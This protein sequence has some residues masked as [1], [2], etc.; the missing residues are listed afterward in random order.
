MW[1]GE[2]VFGS[3]REIDKEI[4]AVNIFASALTRQSPSVLS[5]WRKLIEL[6]PTSI[7]QSLQRRQA[8]LAT[9][10]V[11]AVDHDCPSVGVV[12][13][14]VVDLQLDICGTV[15]APSGLLQPTNSLAH[16]GAIV[17]SMNWCDLGSLFGH[18]ESAL[19]SKWAELPPWSYRGNLVQYVAACVDNSS[20]KA[21]V[22]TN[23]YVAM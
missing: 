17:V 18:W 4:V 1:T 21:V 15:K 14:V 7:E 16:C 19:N 9:S 23:S 22:S 10:R 3:K 5:L 6:R 2:I 11:V 8:A 20:P 12:A 13:D